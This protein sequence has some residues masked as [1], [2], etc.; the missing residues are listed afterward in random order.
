MKQMFPGY[1][2]R[3]DEEFKQLWEDC[4]FTFDANVL[5]N[6]YRYTEATRE[7]LLDKFRQLEDRIWLSYQAAYEYQ[8]QRKSVIRKQEKFYED[9][10]QQLTPKEIKLDF[11][12]GFS[13]F[14]VIDEEMLSEKIR[15][16][17]E[18]FQQ[19]ITD[20]VDELAH[21]GES[22]S[23]WLQTDTIRDELDTLFADKVGSFY[24]ADRLNEI[25]QIGEARYQQEQPPGYKDTDKST[26][27]KYGDL[28]L[29]FQIIDYAKDSKKSIVLITD[30]RK[31]DWWQVEG[32]K[33]LGP[34]PE[35]I[36]EIFHKASVQFY[37]YTSD[38]FLQYATEYLN[39][40]SADTSIEEIEEVAEQDKVLL[41]HNTL[42]PWVYQNDWLK[43]EREY[44]ITRKLQEFLEWRNNQI[45]GVTF[46]N[47]QENE[48]FNKIQEFSEWRDN[49]I[50][51]IAFSS[52][53][54]NNIL[55][56]MQ[57]FNVWQDQHLNEIDIFTQQADLIL[58][59]MEDFRTSQDQRSRNIAAASAQ[60]SEALKRMRELDE[61]QAQLLS[62]VGSFAIL[63]DIE[64][65]NT[66][67]EDTESDND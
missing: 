56:K 21:E 40:K 64:S 23:N 55:H 32:G 60:E 13:R 24:S 27:K 17:Y 6:L 52:A 12:K 11:L 57:E 47:N 19:K 65:L 33:T 3:S 26:T 39:L 38:R 8:M 67:N 16:L 20:I 54:E 50:A 31:E 25:Y 1:Y 42:T 37:M 63:P 15:T 62:D 7:D 41:K 35:L 48:L 59:Q 51:N 30:D 18:E 43:Q 53:Q 29:W 9:I 66:A 49:Q 34:R 2:E 22:H 61:E 44:E 46:S 5:L 4:I 45:H 58:K 14:G 28:L 10:K 36:Q